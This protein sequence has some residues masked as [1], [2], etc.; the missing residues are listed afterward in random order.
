MSESLKFTHSL[1]KPVLALL[2]PIHPLAMPVCRVSWVRHKARSSLK[3]A[4]R[5]D[6]AVWEVLDIAGYD[7][8]QV[9]AAHVRA[10]ARA[11]GALAKTDPIDARLIAEFMAFRPHCGRK[12]PA[13]KLRHLN[14]LSTKR[15]QLVE[16]RKRLKCQIQQHHDTELVDLDTELLD[17]LSH[18]I[19]MLE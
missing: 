18:Q 14:A 1:A 19:K 5:Y 8:R 17:L 7:V 3:P 9:S 4:G 16:L 12:L 13:E 15:R 11:T 6:W 10:F 2:F